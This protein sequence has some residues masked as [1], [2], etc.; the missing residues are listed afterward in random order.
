MCFVSTRII[1]DCDPG[2][3]D[4]M[5]ILLALRSDRLQLEAITTVAGNVEVDLATTNVLRVLEVAGAEKIRVA[6]GMAKP[7]LRDLTTATEVHGLDGLGNTNMPPP[8]SRAL[9]IHAVDLLVSQIMK[10]P[11][12]ITLVALGPLTNVA[13]AIT[14][15]PRLKECVKE[16]VIMGGA[17]TVPGN[18]TSQAEFNVY[19]DP[20]AA[21]IVLNS[22]LPITL[23]GLDVTRKT[24]LTPAHLKRI[25][26]TSSGVSRFLGR[27]ARH[28]MSFYKRTRGV[29]GCALH[30]PLAVGVAFDRSLVRTQRMLLDVETRGELCLGRTVQLPSPVAG[31]ETG[32]EVCL[33]VDSERF[34]EAFVQAL[35]H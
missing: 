26:K 2:I 35:S 7:L 9:P 22:E 19:V 1:L 5:A 18:V 12:E 6:R 31:R 13:M 17:V 16:V 25:E 28:Y 32:V 33:E 20:E 27:I 24:L 29:E 10:K 15:E 34:L 30:D 8:K 14:K 4:A 21:R 3:D 11:G 23:V